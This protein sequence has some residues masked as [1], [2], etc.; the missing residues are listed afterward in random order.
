MIEYSQ[1]LK[2]DAQ[3]AATF[4]VVNISQYSRIY[5]LF[6]KARFLLKRAYN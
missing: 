6:Y 3:Y 5:I 1:I 2:C 4:T